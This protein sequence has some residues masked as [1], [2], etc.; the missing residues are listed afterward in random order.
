MKETKKELRKRITKE[1]R[2]MDSIERENLS[3]S[4]V[5]KILANPIFEKY[6][7]VAIYCSMIDE[8]D[9]KIL[10]DRLSKTKK[11]LLPH[12]YDN[13]MKFRSFVSWDD[14][15]VGEYNIIS[16]RIDD[17]HIWNDREKI[18]IVPALA[19]DKKKYRLGRG[20]GYYDRYL[21][22]HTKDYTIGVSLYETLEELPSDE[23]DIA[24]K[25]IITASSINNIKSTKI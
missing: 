2:S 15:Q 14:M 16:P 23:W 7:I 20:A 17:S 19:F 11:V 13:D 8:I 18:I 24:M 6:D 1:I 3:N 21:S 5:E 22:T 12:T 9:S 10:I 25:E 4:L